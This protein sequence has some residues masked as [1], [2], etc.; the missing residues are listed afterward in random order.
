MMGWYVGDHMTGWG[1]LGMT[2]GSLLFVVLLVLGGMLLIRF[3]RRPDGPAAP[4][5][6]AERILAERYARGELTDEQYRQQLATLRGT[7]APTR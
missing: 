1:W 6:S 3:S 2:L 4:S 7:G 5:G